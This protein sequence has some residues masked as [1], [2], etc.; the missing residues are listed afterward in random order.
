MGGGAGSHARDI[1][2][3]HADQGVF[4]IPD[5]VSDERALFA[6]AAAPIGWTGGTSGRWAAG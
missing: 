3:P 5:D 6:S 2:V 1:R 4:A